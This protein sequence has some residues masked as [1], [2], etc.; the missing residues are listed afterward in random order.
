MYTLVCY[1]A[2]RYIERDD[3]VHLVSK[4]RFRD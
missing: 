4:S 2:V 1:R 3:H